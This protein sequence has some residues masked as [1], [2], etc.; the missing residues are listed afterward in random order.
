MRSLHCISSV[1]PKLDSDISY[2]CAGTPGRI[3]C[4]SRETGNTVSKPRAI[5]YVLLGY[6][7]LG[8]F[9]LLSCN[10]NS[11]LMAKHLDGGTG[12]FAAPGQHYLVQEAC[13][14]K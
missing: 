8:L 14:P 13:P 7:L 4:D 2:G 6:I 1:K 11:A 10:T 5:A 3:A 9:S 12:F